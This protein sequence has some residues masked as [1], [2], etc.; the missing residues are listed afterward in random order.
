MKDH[1]ILSFG[2]LPNLVGG[3]DLMTNCFKETSK[4]NIS[5]IEVS[6]ISFNQNQLTGQKREQQQKFATA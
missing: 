4:I 6:A 1:S 5:L 3:P 2:E